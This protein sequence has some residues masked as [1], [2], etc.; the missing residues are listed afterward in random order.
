MRTE[1]TIFLLLLF[2]IIAIIVLR[3]LYNKYNKK[4]LMISQDRDDG[5]VKTCELIYFYTTWCPYCN[6]ARPEWDAFRREW[7]G[8]SFKGYYITFTEVDCDA[9]EATA[10]KYDVKSYPTIKLKCKG[11]V[12]EYDARPTQEDLNNFLETV[13]PDPKFKKN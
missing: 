7:E 13:L 10:K 6:K 1:Y 12:V 11:E 4:K 2:G 5:S 9:D 8:N 3:Q